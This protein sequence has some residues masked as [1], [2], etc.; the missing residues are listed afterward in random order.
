M[1]SLTE[2]MIS[3]NDFPGFKLSD[4]CWLALEANARIVTRALF[5]AFGKAQDRLCVLIRAPIL[6]SL[7]W[8]LGRAVQATPELGAHCLSL[9]S[10]RAAGVGEPHRTPEGPRHGQ[11]GFGHFCRTKSGSSFGGETP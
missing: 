7:A 6:G 4:A 1:S 5:E 8:W 2:R 11:N 10:L 3:Q 9:A